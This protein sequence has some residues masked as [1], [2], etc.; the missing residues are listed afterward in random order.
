M[1]MPKSPP[2][3]KDYLDKKGDTQ[4][5]VRALSEVTES[6]ISGKYL[7]WHKLRF[8]T[9]PEGL[10]HEEWWFGIKMKRGSQSR[11]IGLLDK[12]GKQFSY[13]LVDPLP[14]FLHL[15]DSDTRGSLRT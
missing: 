12:M 2:Q 7:H 3:L 1:R 10:T 8:Y 6:T 4:W 15:A 9:P 5:L 11:R 14:E 13:N